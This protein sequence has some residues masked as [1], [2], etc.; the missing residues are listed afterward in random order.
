MGQLPANHVDGCCRRPPVLPIITSWLPVIDNSQSLTGLISVK[1]PI[2]K[3]SGDPIESAMLSYY[4]MV[5][6][7]KF[8]N[9]FELTWTAFLPYT[10]FELCFEVHIL[11]RTHAWRS[12]FFWRW[13]SPEVYKEQSARLCSEVVGRC[14]GSLVAQYVDSL[15]L[16]FLQFVLTASQIAL[17][18]R[19]QARCRLVLL[20][21]DVFR[22]SG[23]A[24][25][26]KNRGRLRAPDGVMLSTSA[27]APRL[28][29]T[30]QPPA[31]LEPPTCKAPPLLPLHPSYA[32]N[33]HTRIP[34]QISNSHLH[35]RLLLAPSTSTPPPHL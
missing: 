1:G 23:L 32:A 7:T 9:G 20:A 2:V 18:R 16:K 11:S 35:A 26:Q 3:R 14:Q 19:L 34:R 5:T 21:A 22:F 6:V 33:Q 27:P 8:S 12:V 30:L 31:A 25:P 10:Y 24:T 13:G 28:V 15:K 4:N 17:P 29:A